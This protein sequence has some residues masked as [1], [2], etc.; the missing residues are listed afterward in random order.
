[1]PGLEIRP[2]QNTDFDAVTI[3]W[4]IAREISLP[5][6]QREKGYFFYQD[7]DYFAG[8]VLPNHQ[9][10]VAALQGQPV[11]FMALRHDFIDQLYVHPAYWRKGIGAALL[12][13]ARQLS[14]Q[15]LWLYTLQANTQ[16]RTFYEKQGFIAKR[17]GF[18]PPPESAPDV[19]Y[20][21]RGNAR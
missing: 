13:H 20:H 3:L 4:R 8:H 18:S 14:P 16:A 17:F 2:Y 7:R 9:V 21:W 5:Q 10:W 15:H 11:A 1:M 19:E 6:I 12:A